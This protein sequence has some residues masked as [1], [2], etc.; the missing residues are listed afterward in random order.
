MLR[1][2]SSLLHAHPPLRQVA[3]RLFVR[4]LAVESGNMGGA[5]KGVKPWTPKKL[6]R[7]KPSIFSAVAKQSPFLS[8]E[9]ANPTA[10]KTQAQPSSRLVTVVRTEEDAKA[11]LEV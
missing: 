3:T 5:K 10:S 7:V 6:P 2:S 11:A 1:R 4:M 9:L 8:P